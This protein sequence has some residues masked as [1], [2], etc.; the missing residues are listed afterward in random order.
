M[1]IFH[2]KKILTGKELIQEIEEN[3]DE[4][5]LVN[6]WSN[7]RELTEDLKSIAERQNRPVDELLLW[8]M[9]LKQRIDEDAQHG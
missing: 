9:N 1:T 6:T 3:V 7:W 5:L 8:Y 4:Y 2:S